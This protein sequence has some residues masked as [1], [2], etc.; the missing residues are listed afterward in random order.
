MEYFQAS[1]YTFTWA[2]ICLIVPPLAK[3]CSGLLRASR[4]ICFYTI[5]LQQQ[6]RFVVNMAR[7][8]CKATFF[9]N[10]WSK[11][12]NNNR[13]ARKVYKVHECDITLFFA[14]LHLWSGLDYIK[15][16]KCINLFLSILALHLDYYFP[17]WNKAFYR[18]ASGVSGSAGL[19]L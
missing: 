10:E 15:T 9:L 7:L 17:P 4:P 16:A 13:M 6:I 19:Q 12:I 3:G 5:E 14:S 2:L 18:M 11:C 1:V 8:L